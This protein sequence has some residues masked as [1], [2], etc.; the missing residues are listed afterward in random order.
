MYNK[1]AFSSIFTMAHFLPDDNNSM[2]L[3]QRYK[4]IQLETQ[5]MRSLS[6]GNSARCHIECLQRDTSLEKF[7]LGSLAL[8][9][10]WDA[11]ETKSAVQTQR[12]LSLIG[13]EDRKESHCL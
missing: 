1:N 3:H 13:A 11:N 8:N 5:S 12:Q 7:L 10:L 2:V 6:Q 9:R 4:M